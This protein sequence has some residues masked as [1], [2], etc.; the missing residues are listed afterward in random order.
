M[1]IPDAD[2]GFDDDDIVAFLRLPL[3]TRA[4]PLLAEA[5]QDQ[6]RGEL[7]MIGRGGFLAFARARRRSPGG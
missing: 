4:L 6:Y 5:L 3:D 1:E 2:D 7:R